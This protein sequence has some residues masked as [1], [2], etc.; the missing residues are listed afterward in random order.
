MKIVFVFSVKNTIET[1]LP[2]S[3]RAIAPQ[4][5]QT[6]YGMTKQGWKLKAQIG[7]LWPELQLK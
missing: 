3:W 2:D 6:Q 4:P 1:F 5:S 7:T